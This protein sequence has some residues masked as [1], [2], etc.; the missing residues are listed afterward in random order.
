MYTPFDKATA[1]VTDRISWALCQIID[2]D[3]P[4]RWTRYRGAAE[5]IARNPEVM[6]DLLEL[7]GANF[8][9][10]YGLGTTTTVCSEHQT[11]DPSCRRCEPIA[12][13][14]P[15]GGL[16]PCR[17]FCDGP[18]GAFFTDNLK[19]ARDILMVF[20]KFDDWTVTDLKAEPV[21]E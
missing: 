17:Y 8:E 18:Q 1:S 12:V 21:K 14:D 3:A 9:K 15:T 11:P 16:Y 2:D 19:L 5:C 6:K 13:G 7:A 10:N 4:L 20:D